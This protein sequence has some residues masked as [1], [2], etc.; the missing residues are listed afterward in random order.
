MVRRLPTSTLFPYTTLFRSGAVCT[1]TANFADGTT[2]SATVTVPVIPAI[3]SV[4][5]STGAPGTSPTVTVAGTNFQAGATATFGAGITVSSTTVVSATQLTVALTIGSTATLGPRDVVVTNPNGQTAMRTGGFTVAP[6]PATLSLA[7][8]G[9]V[10]DKVGGGNASFGPDGGL[11]GSFQ[12]TVG[13][14][15]GARTVTRLELR[16]GGGVWDTDTATA[17]WA[18]GAATRLDSA[19][20]D[21]GNGA[22]SVGVAGGWGVSGFAV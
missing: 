22:V 8:L 19:L 3:T 2:A 1:L 17:H 12:V 20:L 5:P 21:G 4:T 9:K 11:D 7:Y 16:G 14:G 15:S 6:P 13:A 18:L 10:R